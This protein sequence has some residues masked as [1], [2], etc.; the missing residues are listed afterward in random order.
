MLAAPVVL[1]AAA[2]TLQVPADTLHY[3][4]VN[5]GR[6]AG[7]MQVIAVA[8]TVVVTSVLVCCVDQTSRG[9]E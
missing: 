5:H 9:A 6:H 2:V 3:Q 8:D 1:I 4:V 7:T